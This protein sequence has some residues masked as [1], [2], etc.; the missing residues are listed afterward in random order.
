MDFIITAPL[1]FL[2][3]ILFFL[4]MNSMSKE[5]VVN[6]IDNKIVGMKL[7]EMVS[8][9]PFNEKG[10]FVYEV[11][12]KEDIQILKTI[13]RNDV[14]EFPYDRIDGDE[15]IL[16]IKDDIIEGFIAKWESTPT[17][18][19]S[20]SFSNEYGIFC[21]FSGERGVA[22]EFD[23]EDRI[24][25][26]VGQYSKMPTDAILSYISSATGIPVVRANKQ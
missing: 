6:I 3:Q 17:S 19:G 25:C 9:T 18:G 23:K 2:K 20:I 21:R 26:S 11:E 4:F 7:E 10:S 15:Y 16:K 13:A 24:L 14:A 1:I 12:K 22:V 5:K 8:G